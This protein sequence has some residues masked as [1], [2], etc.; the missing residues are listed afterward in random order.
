MLLNK[1]VFGGGF[2]FPMTLSFFHF[3]FTIGWYQM[4]AIGGAFSKPEPGKDLPQSEKFKV[5]AAGFA[6]IGFMN[7][8]L[9]YNSVG[10]YQVRA[11]PSSVAAMARHVRPP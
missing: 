8:S 7:L 1:R 11:L 2:A 5:A 6:S 4:L 3:L 10:F 9:S